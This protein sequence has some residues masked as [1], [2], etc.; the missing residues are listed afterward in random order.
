MTF[1]GEEEDDELEVRTAE[2]IKKALS[3]CGNKI[4]KLIREEEEEEEDQ[5]EADAEGGEEESEASSEDGEYDVEAILR[6]Q[7]RIKRG[8]RKRVTHYLIKWQ[9]QS[10]REEPFESKWQP[11]LTF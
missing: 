2:K 8:T 11:T 4:R 5:D 7:K 9:G 3:V 6:R 10:G 1:E